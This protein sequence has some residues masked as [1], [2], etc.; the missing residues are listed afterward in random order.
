MYSVWVYWGGGGEVFEAGVDDDP[1]P[2][3]AMNRAAVVLNPLIFLHSFARFY[4]HS[5]C[6]SMVNSE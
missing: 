2:P 5:K 6:V 3:A 1:P 4:K